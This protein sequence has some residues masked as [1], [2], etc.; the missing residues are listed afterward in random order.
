MRARRPETCPSF[1]P[2]PRPPDF[3]GGATA[4]TLHGVSELPTFDLLELEQCDASTSFRMPARPALCTPFGFLYGGSGI[5]ASAEA[6]ERATGRPLQWI[7]TQFLGSP[8]PGS[9]VE[10]EVNVAVT[11]RASSQT[12][13]SGTVDGELVFTSLCAHNV[14]PG[15]DEHVFSEMPDVPPPD[16]CEAFGEPFGLDGTP[17]FFDSLDRRVAVGTIRFDP[18]DPGFGQPQDGGVAMWCRIVDDEVGSPATQGFV[19]D[20]G[21][22]AVCARLGLPLGGTS[23][24]NTIRVVDP[25]P[26]D[27]VLLE[28]GADSVQRSVGHSTVRVWARDGRLL[29]LAQQSAIIRTSHH[30]RPS[31]G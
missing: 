1:E 21:P 5:A 3:V 15:G 26:S 20:L 18:E 25:D 9:V 7:T 17:S 8:A 28:L 2:E 11:G 22:L 4:G 10:L 16:E 19:A 23:L 12:Q 30:T 27:W 6:S 14:R 24:D 29:G 13:V 31:P